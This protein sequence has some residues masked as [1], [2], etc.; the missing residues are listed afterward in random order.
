M[1]TKNTTNIEHPARF[2]SMEEVEIYHLEELEALAKLG[3]NTT[4]MWTPALTENVLQWIK[5]KG[6]TCK[7]Y[8]S[9]RT[10][11][12]GSPYVIDMEPEKDS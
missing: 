11:E 4:F 3:G 8:G 2:A 12:D 7:V 1:A 5:S 6:Y 10:E 9:L